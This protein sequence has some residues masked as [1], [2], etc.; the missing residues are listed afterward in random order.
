M[1]SELTPFH[2]A[3]ARILA[4]FALAWGLWSCAS[5]PAKLDYAPGPGRSAPPRSGGKAILVREE[6][7][8][9]LDPALSYGTYS[10]PVNEAVYHTLL[11]YEGVPGAAGA[12]LRPDLAETLPQVREGGTLYCFK[13]RADARFG[14][15]LRRHI[16]AADCKYSIERLF[17]VHS[18][19]MSFYRSIVGASDVLAGRGRTLAGVVA[20]GDSLY[21][22][23]TRPDPVFPHILAMTFT[24][25]VPSEVAERYPNT[26]S[27]HTVATGPFRVAEFVP[28][29]RVL[30]VRNQDYCG[31]PAY[32]DTIEVRLGVTAVNAVAM[33]R[34]GL[35]DGGFFTVPSAEYIR[36]S[37]DSV[38]K[39][40]L[41]LADGLNTEYLFFNVREKPFDDVRVRQ[42]VGW[43]LDRRALVKVYAG[44]GTAAGELL[45]LGMP[46]A[47]PLGRYQGPDL[48]RARALLREAGYP[49]GFSTKLYGWT[50]EPGP[51]ELALV[52]QQLESI[53]IR[54]ELDLGEAAAYNALAGD[55][56]RH[57]PFGIYSW[58][59]DYVDPSNFFDPLL[60][61][62]RISPLYNN[63]LSLFDDPWVNAA[64]ERALATTDDSLRVPMWQEIDRRVMDLAP[65]MPMIHTFE[66]RLYSPRLGGWYRH[67][68]R[69]LKL[70]QL[71]L[72]SPAQ[73]RALAAAG[74]NTR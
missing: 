59:A 11:D 21:V 6:D 5:H 23:L 15:P 74:S 44:Q 56:S 9:Y 7:P 70:E 35:A 33:I 17:K 3:R 14:P 36:L 62:H 12:R 38:W 20:R 24:S 22:R 18:P 50:T 34:K 25:P 13:L 60:N 28:R 37:R 47:V 57:V 19:G 29:R 49:N 40:Q 42:A 51:R 53:G 63:N 65:V 2:A 69:I 46:G 10:A 67:I 66:S 27:Q 52:Q 48:E 71:Y 31:P 43:S 41:D 55:T 16:T 64:I 8:D 72:K 4:V 26:L 73:P 30:L 54:A 1:S 68:T 58:T 32:L 61:G 45:P 39:H